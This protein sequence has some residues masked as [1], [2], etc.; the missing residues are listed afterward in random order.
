MT[1]I[2]IVLL[3]EETAYEKLLNDLIDDQKY[4]KLVRPFRKGKLRV[5]TELKILS[6]SLVWFKVLLI[7]KFST[8]NFCD[9]VI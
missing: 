7:I 3:Y 4:N 2:E 9:F 6:L 5:E 8:K 1:S